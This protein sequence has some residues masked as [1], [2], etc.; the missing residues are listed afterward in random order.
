M[1]L[2]SAKCTSV[3][4]HRCQLISGSKTAYDDCW[5]ARVLAQV[6]VKLVLLA[7]AF[8]ADYAL[9]RFEL[10]VEPYVRLHIA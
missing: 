4:N 3:S 6:F 9:V 8:L 2:K 1:F 10:K 7:K 5:R